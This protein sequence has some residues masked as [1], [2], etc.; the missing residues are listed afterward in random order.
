M[1]KITLTIKDLKKKNFLIQLLQ[2]FDFVEIQKTTEK[3]QED[4]NFF[5]SAGLFKN[6]KINAK[7][8]RENAWK[9]K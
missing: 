9:R 7:K 2:Q 3:W 4:Y 6:R 5:A 1:E 8:L